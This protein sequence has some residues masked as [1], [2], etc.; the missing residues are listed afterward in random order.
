MPIMRPHTN[1]V[2]K[3]PAL[4]E[5]LKTAGRDPKSAPV[6]IFFAPPRR[7]A[8][9]A[10]AAAGVQRAIFGLPAAPRDEVLPKLDA[11]AA[12]MRA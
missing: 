10:L 8:L 11:Y 5:R 3:I 7:E 9:D 1:P 4:R 12:V 2:D 6:S